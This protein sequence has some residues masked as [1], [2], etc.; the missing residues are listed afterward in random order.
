MCIS[1]KII[2][3]KPVEN[4][5]EKWNTLIFTQREAIPSQEKMEGAVSGKQPEAA[6]YFFEKRITPKLAA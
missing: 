4:P 1:P 6:L 3:E 2:R 5:V